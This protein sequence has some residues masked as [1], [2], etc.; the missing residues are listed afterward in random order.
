MEVYAQV[1]WWQMENERMLHCSFFMV[2]A[3][4]VFQLAH[5][6]TSY[7]LA[8]LNNHKTIKDRHFKWSSKPLCI[9]LYL[10]LNPRPLCSKA[11]VIPTRP[12][13]VWL[14]GA[15]LNHAQFR[16]CT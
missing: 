3:P 2:Y 10:G 7:Q 1:T 14:L 11:S 9:G 4:K 8:C 15:S 5:F 6:P 13:Y 16:N 12:Q